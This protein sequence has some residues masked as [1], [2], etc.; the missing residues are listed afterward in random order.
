MTDAANRAVLVFSA[1]GR[2]L[3]AWGK[4]GAR[5]GEFGAVG[6]IVVTD[7]GNVA[8]ADAAAGQI[9]LF[10]P[11]GKFLR[12]LG[13]R[14]AGDGGVVFLGGFAG[15]RDGRF[16][17]A[18]IGEDTVKRLGDAAGGASE[19]PIGTGSGNLQLL[20]PVAIDGDGAG[21]FFVAEGAANRVVCF[22]LAPEGKRP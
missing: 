16:L 1:E 18:D 10:S 22:R 3:A 19:L 6:A 21:R 15:L 12:A 8:V 9:K 2:Q 7:D 5:P 14:A 4:A 13:A 17:A 20:G 11:A